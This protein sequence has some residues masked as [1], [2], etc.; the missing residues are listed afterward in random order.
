MPVPVRLQ[1]MSNR[2]H[3]IHT[4]ECMEVFRDEGEATTGQGGSPGMD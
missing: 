1:A 2:G 4:P 3:T